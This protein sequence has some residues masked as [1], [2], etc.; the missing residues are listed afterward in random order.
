M[1]EYFEKRA[2]DV[3]SNGTE[4]SSVEPIATA[5]ETATKTSNGSSAAVSGTAT[6]SGKHGSSTTSAA[7]SAA[8]TKAAKA[9]KA[10]SPFLS[11]PILTRG[12]LFYL[13]VAVTLFLWCTGKAI[14]VK[15]ERQEK[16][17]ES[18]IHSI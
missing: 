3:A 17:A 15:I 4:T 10:K 7:S 13:G 9:A 1:Y 5:I 16:Y 18:R 12:D 11:V 2:E 14:D 8:T 6:A